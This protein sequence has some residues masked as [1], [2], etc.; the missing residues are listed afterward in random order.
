MQQM[1][2]GL[3]GLGKMGAGMAY[4]LTKGGHQVVGADISA[5]AREQVE[6]E[7]AVAASDVASLVQLLEAPRVVWVMLPAGKLTRDAIAELANHLS[8][9]DLVIDGGNSDFRDAPAHAASLGE[10]GID[11]AD[12]GVSGGQWGRDNGY[13]LMVGASSE[14]FAR[15]EP[16][17]TSLSADGDYSLVGGLGS[18]HLVK[19]IH[20]GVQYAILQAYAEGYALLSAHPEVDA[21][22]ALEAWQGGSSVRSWLLS[23]IIAALQANPTL[24]GVTSQVSDSGMGRWTAEE[25]IRLA[26][27]TP[28]LTLA[29]HQ[30]FASRD[31]GL[32][33]KLLAATRNQVGGQK[34]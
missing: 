27:P 16:A 5:A 15:I 26:V 17:L 4:R 23:Q 1:Q 9:G 19:A 33:N 34:A 3:L 11:F 14:A 31:D 28:A 2:I 20:N 32:A 6:A 25:A 10:K 13:G 30:R 8:E 12:V 21:L 29:L 18:G 22:A 24:E 7:G